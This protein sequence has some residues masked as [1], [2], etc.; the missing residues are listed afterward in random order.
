MVGIEIMHF[1]K[2]MKK[3]NEEC[4]VIKLDISKACDNI[5]WDY[6]RVIMEKMEFFTTTGGVED[7]NTC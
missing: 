5:D 3:G 7:D 2:T 1:K 6:L 4:V